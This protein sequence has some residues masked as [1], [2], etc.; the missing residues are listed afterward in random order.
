MAAA[1]AALNNYFNDTLGI[2]DPPARVALNNKGL[3]AFD[4]FL[5][6]TKK[7]ISEI[8]TNI[9]KPS[10]MIPN[11]VH[12][13]AAPVAG[14]PPV[15]PNPGIQLGFVFEKRLKMLRYYLLHLKRIQWPMGVAQATLARLTIC[16]RLNDAE[17]E[18]EEV[19]LPELT[20]YGR[21]KPCTALHEQKSVE[22]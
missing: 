13:A 18:E 12:N 20:K 16:Y 22:A 5:T 6:L 21:Y 11:P 3:K 7:D 4:D 9:R 10:G 2:V 19:D 1:L 15:I 17:T 14:I 8:C